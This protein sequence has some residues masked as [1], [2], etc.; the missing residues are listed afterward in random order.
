MG[1]PACWAHLLDDEGRVR[2]ELISISEDAREDSDGDES[3]DENQKA[4]QPAP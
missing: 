4:E 1:D 3:R 2:E